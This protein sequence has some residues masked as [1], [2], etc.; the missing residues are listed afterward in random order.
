MDLYN[1][2]LSH[3]F[4]RR[5]YFTTSFVP[6]IGWF[7][8]C[9]VRKQELVFMT[10]CPHLDYRREVS[11]FLKEKTKVSCTENSKWRLSCVAT[12]LSSYQF[13]CLT[14]Q[15]PLVP[16]VRFDD[17]CFIEVRVRLSPAV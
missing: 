15:L 14:A 12:L 11:R 4:G 1:K 7:G 5:Q 6:L 13:E 16:L 3:L 10:K 17:V 9:V 8:I 2:V